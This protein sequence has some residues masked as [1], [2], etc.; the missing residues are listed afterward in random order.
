MHRFHIWK[1]WTLEMTYRLHVLFTRWDY[2]KSFSIPYA[3]EFSGPFCS[4]PIL[5]RINTDLFLKIYE[6]IRVG[7]KKTNGNMNEAWWAWCFCKATF[8]AVADK[9]K[10]IAEIL[11]RERFI[12]HKNIRNRWDLSRNGCLGTSLPP[13][14]ELLTTVV[15]SYIIYIYSCSII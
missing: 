13:P 6:T 11:S 14:A 7:Y 8:Y 4:F 3:A 5:S 9:D 2:F 15:N 1:K 10:H 12:G